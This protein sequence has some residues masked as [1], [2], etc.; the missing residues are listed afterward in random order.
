MKKR[1]SVDLATRAALTAGIFLFVGAIG[2]GAPASAEPQDGGD[3]IG[4]PVAGAVKSI[5]LAPENG[6]L[7]DALAREFR[8][9]GY[10]VVDG[11]GLAPSPSFAQLKAQGIDA[12]LTV[13]TAG[14]SDDQPQA[15]S[16]QINSTAT[17][18]VMA[19]I[20]WQNGWGGWRGSKASLAN[21][22]MHKNLVQAAREIADG[23][24]KTLT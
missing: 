9:R 23:L 7:G 3:V 15:A 21:R 20:T 4:A 5:V 24:V 18:G 1:S 11:K 12:V 6:P 8:N 13:R 16:V 10:T 14:G 17:G 22:V 2:A 19:K